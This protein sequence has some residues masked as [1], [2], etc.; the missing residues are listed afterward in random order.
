MILA[1]AGLFLVAAPQG[2]ELKGVVT[3]NDER[4]IAGAS[5]YISSAR[6]RRGVGV[7]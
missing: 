2:A 3:S 7:L 5:V 6:P 1:L 4:P